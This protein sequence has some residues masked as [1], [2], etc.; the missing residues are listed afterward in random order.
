M[1]FTAEKS[2]LFEV[3]QNAE[4]GVPTGTPSLPV[5]SCLYLSADDT[6]N[7]ITF[8][9]T[10]LSFGVRAEGTARVEDSGS[11]CVNARLFS[12]V[13]KSLE[14]GAVEVELSS[15]KRKLT[16]SGGASHFELLTIAANE[17]PAG[18][19]FDESQ[20]FSIDASILTK[21]LRKV[22]G[23]TSNDGSRPVLNG[24]HII[25]DKENDT[26]SFAA[27]DSYRLSVVKLS[28]LT[29]NFTDDIEVTIPSKTLDELV[30]FIDSDVDKVGVVLTD[31]L[32]QFRVGSKRLST[33]LI[34]GKYPAYET[35]MNVAA[36][37]TVV[38]D[39]EALIGTLK[40]VQ[41]M[42]DASAVVPARFDFGVEGA[43]AKVSCS[44]T[45][46]GA[47]DERID[48]TLTP[49]TDDE[50]TDGINESLHDEV[51]EDT[52][53]FSIGFNPKYMSE[54]LSVFAGN[55]VTMHIDNPLKP[56]LLT[57][58][59]VPELRYILMPVKL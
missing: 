48:V 22:V 4:R 30:R 36:K 2:E 23:A 1:K 21:A 8:R 58:A 40:R 24:V 54:G 31:K 9:G 13:V 29:S 6:S 55:E 15:D 32:V 16:V 3:I 41:V 57:S 14:A 35:L 38:V 37:Y 52:I 17:Y 7:K 25:V 42:N 20:E 12:S 26:L 50:E 11:V 39:P 43:G 47:A 53:V 28:G 19:T 18:E 51:S 49:V 59:S 5:L 56:V 33:R 45:D 27:T 44:K 46:I 34:E 10:D